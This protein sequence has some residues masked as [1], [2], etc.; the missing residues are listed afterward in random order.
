LPEQRRSAAE[1]I[2]AA[3]NCALDLAEVG[4]SSLGALDRQTLMPDHPWG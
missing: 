3:M 4:L 1:R 2:G